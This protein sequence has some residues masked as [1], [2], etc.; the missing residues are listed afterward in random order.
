MRAPQVRIGASSA[1]IA[2]LLAASWS[3]AQP[4]TAA[5]LTGFWRIDHPAAMLPTTSA[6]P[7]LLP[8][9]RSLYEQHLAQRARGDLSFDDAG[10][11]KGAGIP[12]QLFMPGEL[13]ILQEPRQIFMLFGWNRELRVI[14]VG[15]S[16][17]QQNLYAPT[18]YGFSTGEWRDGILSVDSV[19][20]NDATILDDA[21]LPH[22]DALHVVERYQLRERGRRLQI[23]ITIDDPKTYARPWTTSATLTRL[24]DDTII[25]EDICVQRLHL[26]DRPASNKL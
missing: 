26:T 13:Q 24:P 25:P 19:N 3:A 12:R 16:H 22:S 18:Y 1:A 11:C 15:I 8:A 21:G 2:L 14:D 5:D 9:A 4:A 7:P 6:G 20:F 10:V 17:A 23:D